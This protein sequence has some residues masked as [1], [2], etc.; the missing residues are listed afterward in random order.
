MEYMMMILMMFVHVYVAFVY[1]DAINLI[2]LRTQISFLF[3]PS[4]L[5]RYVNVLL[6]KEEKLKKRKGK[7]INTYS[8]NL[9][10]YVNILYI[11][12]YYFP[13]IALLCRR[14]HK[15][16]LN[17]TLQ[18]KYNKRFRVCLNEMYYWRA[19]V[20]FFCFVFSC[21]NN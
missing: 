2:F 21:N 5:F 7:Y 3:F 12:I 16:I 18:I 10:S 9:R 8:Q 13:L 17:C 14:M 6:R 19:I 11:F 20:E 1:T 15:Y 4:F